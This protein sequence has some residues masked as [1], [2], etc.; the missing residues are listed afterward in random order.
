MAPSINLTL[1]L[2]PRDRFV[3]CHN[4]W[5]P[6]QLITITQGLIHPQCHTLLLISMCTA[7]RLLYM[8]MHVSTLCRL[9]I[10]LPMKRCMSASSGVSGGGGAQGAQSPP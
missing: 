8:Y 7:A 4:S 10:Y 2:R 1:K 3:Y 6:M 5:A 9:F